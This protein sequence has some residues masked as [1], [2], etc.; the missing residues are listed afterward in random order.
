[1]RGLY[2]AL[3]VRALDRS[4]NSE[5]T[6][7][8]LHAEN[9][10]RREIRSDR[11]RRSEMLICIASAAVAAAI[12]TADLIIPAEIR[13]HGLYVFPLAIVGRYCGQLLW[14]AV[15]LIVTTVLQY[16]AFS[17]QVV[18]V[19]SAMSDVLV[20]FATSVLTLFLARSW[21]TSYLIALDQAATDSLTDLPNRRAFIAEIDAEIAR[22]QRYGG[23]FSLAVLDLDSFKALNDSKGHRAGDEALKLVAETLRRHTRSSDSLGRIGG[24][25][26]ALLMPNTAADCA[27]T[28]RNLCAAIAAS[29]AT[30]DCAL[31]ASIGCKTFRVPPENA[32][33]A[34][35]EADKVMYEAKSGGKNRAAHGGLDSRAA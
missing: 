1:M 24:D 16:T 12:F 29:T 19:P 27:P 15:M 28:L 21:R 26:F 32:I 5:R 18:A 13:L 17:L 4:K 33:F 3:I 31:T 35:Q 25:E 34:L 9:P 14:P 2:C 8:F 30:A 10:A 11:A 6:V 23:S 22:Q 7:G 20:P